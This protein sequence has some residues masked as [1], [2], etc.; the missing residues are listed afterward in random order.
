MRL[1]CAAVSTR[2]LE[3]ARGGAILRYD[4]SVHS[5]Y[6]A[7]GARLARLSVLAW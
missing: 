3:K 7:L 4:Q 6:V 1:G 2:K 5:G